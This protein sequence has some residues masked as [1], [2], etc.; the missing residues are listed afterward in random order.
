[1]VRRG[2]RNRWLFRIPCGKYLLMKWTMQAGI[3]N[4]VDCDRCKRNDLTRFPLLTIDDAFRQTVF[5]VLESLAGIKLSGA[6]LILRW[7]LW[8][9]SRLDVDSLWRWPDLKIRIIIIIKLNYVWHFQYD[10]PTSGL[11]TGTSLGNGSCSLSHHFIIA[12]LMCNSIRRIKKMH[13]ISL[14]FWSFRM[15]SPH[16]EST[17]VFSLSNKFL[18]GATKSDRHRLIMLHLNK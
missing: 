12:A 8:T 14:T 11:S 4:L 18:D 3:F 13:F 6:L 2:I 16:R 7:P 9:N 1:M 10:A 15:F 17:L 5:T